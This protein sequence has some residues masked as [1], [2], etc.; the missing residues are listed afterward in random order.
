[1]LNIRVVLIIFQL[2][3]IDPNVRL[4]HTCIPTTPVCKTD[5]EIR[6]EQKIQ[7][8]VKLYTIYVGDK[9]DDSDVI[10]P[11]SFSRL[12]LNIVLK[13]SW[14]I[15][16][17]SIIIVIREEHGMED[18][19]VNIYLSFEISFVDVQI[20]YN[21]FKI[22]ARLWS[23]YYILLLIFKYFEPTHRFK[24]PKQSVHANNFL[25]NL[26]FNIWDFY[27]LWVIKAKFVSSTVSE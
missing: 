10:I 18:V 11:V 23:S 22:H 24:I 26:I 21:Y 13:V 5:Y 2:V 14:H 8:C 3:G 17:K 12:P 19:H 6:S 15:Y 7:K 4:T 1:M 9:Y 20:I 16:L 25:K 27:N